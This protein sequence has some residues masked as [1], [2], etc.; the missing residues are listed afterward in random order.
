MA[1]KMRGAQDASYS[2]R[3]S[4]KPIGPIVKRIAKGAQPRTIREKRRSA[5]NCRG[6]KLISAEFFGDLA[7]TA[8]EKAPEY[9][10]QRVGYP[11]PLKG[12]F[13]YYNAK[14]I[15]VLLF[16]YILAL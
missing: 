11:L 4:S 15:C 5:T 7:K 13:F 8:V 12:A 16:D 6:E 2:R 10:R 14:L 3:C 9:L 1:S